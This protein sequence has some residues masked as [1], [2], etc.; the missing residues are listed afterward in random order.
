ME[1]SCPFKRKVFLAQGAQV[2]YGHSA[3]CILHNTHC[4]L[5]TVN[6]TPYNAHYTWKTTHC[7][8]YTAHCTLH[9]V[10]CTLHIEYCTLHNTPCTLYTA[11][12]TLYTT[13]YT[14]HCKLLHPEL[15]TLLSNTN[16]TELWNL[17]YQGSRK[18][19]AS[20]RKCI[21]INCLVL[22]ESSSDYTAK[23]IENLTIG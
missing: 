2:S 20:K 15:C 10:H 11:Y 21:W 19:Q 1:K 23:I 4:T 12:C 9:T 7:T 16:T 6:S 18:W 22:D 8:M 3:H 13:L 5:H 14:V 17:H